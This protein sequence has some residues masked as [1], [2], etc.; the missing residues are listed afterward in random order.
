MTGPSGLPFTSCFAEY[1]SC[2]SAN[3]GGTV[4]HRPAR[5]ADPVSRAIHAE[6]HR[7]RLCKVLLLVR[8]RVRAHPGA[9]CSLLRGVHLHDLRT[10]GRH[11]DVRTHRESE[12]TRHL[13][14][15]VRGGRH[16]VHL[17]L[18]DRDREAS[19]GQLA[20]AF[21]AQLCE[22]T[23]IER[24]RAAQRSRLEDVGQVLAIRHH[25]EDELCRGEAGLDGP[26]WPAPA[27]R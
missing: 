23:T 16:V 8:C 19:V 12:L 17:R 2:R 3:R 26:C 20:P 14:L 11:A 25:D 21:T 10:L 4:F 7:G 15:A 13:A 6:V 24:L 22:A 27:R 5:R 1:S 9:A 18:R